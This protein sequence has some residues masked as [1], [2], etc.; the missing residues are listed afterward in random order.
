[1]ARAPKLCG[2]VGCI[3]LV[4]GQTYCAEH[5][6]QRGWQRGGVTRTDTAA[7]RNRRLRVLARDNH[8]CQLRYDGICT[9]TATVCDHIVPLAEGG[10][11]TDAGCQAACL[12][13]HR[14]KTSIEGHRARGHTVPSE[15]PTATK[16]AGVAGKSR[17]APT[18]APRGI[19]IM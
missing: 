4:R 14:R 8:Q 9:H 6:R 11:D 1:M 7:H 18:R 10:D 15:P 16:P 2:H 17:Q 19:R 5:A 12:E 13:C 3:Q